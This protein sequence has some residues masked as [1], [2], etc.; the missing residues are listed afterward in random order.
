MTPAI[1]KETN[2]GKTVSSPTTDDRNRILGLTRNNWELI[3]NAREIVRRKIS[4]KIEEY[5][6]IFYRTDALSSFRR[7]RC[8]CRCGGRCRGSNGLNRSR[9]RCFYSCRCGSRGAHRGGPWSTDSR[10]SPKS[11]YYR[12]PRHGSEPGRGGRRCHC[13]SGSGRRSITVT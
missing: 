9:R 7:R 12:R 11:R 13:G 1:H 4:R 8:T 6:A 2:R 5:F 10:L 3:R